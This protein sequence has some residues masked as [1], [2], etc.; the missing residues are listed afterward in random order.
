MIVGVGSAAFRGRS[1]DGT[2]WMY[3]GEPGGPDHAPNLLRNVAYGDG[4]FIA[5]GGDANGMVMRSLD[6]VHWQEDVHPT[7][8]CPGDGYPSS[9]TNWMGAVAFHAGTWLAAGGN[10]AIMRSTDGGAT[11]KGLKSMFSEGRIRAM[12]AGSGRFLAGSDGGAIW[13][14]ADDGEHWTKKTPWT[15]AGPSAFL[16][17]AHGAGTFIAFASDFVTS[18]ERACFV[19]ANAGDDWTPCAASIKSNTSFV[20]DGA[21]WVTPASGGYAT[22]T[23]GASWTIHTASNVPTMLLF[24]GTTWFGRSGGTIYRGTSPDDFTKVAMNVSEFRGWAIGSVLEEN[25]PITGVPACQDNR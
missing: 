25:L 1:S 16:Q 2:T 6:A 5:V 4:A 13:V 8:A 18:N 9:C 20:H 12:G 24:D 22:S 21:R 11:W 14:T 3:C 15:A 10:G 23:D 7:T 19:S 17:F